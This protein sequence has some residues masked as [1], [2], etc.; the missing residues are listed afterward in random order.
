MFERFTA[1][2]RAAV[3][4]AAGNARAAGTHEIVLD[5]LLAALLP[6]VPETGLA[7]DAVADVLHDLAEARRRAGLSEAD[8]RALAEF[9]IDLDAV[10]AA[11]ERELGEGV[12]TAG[13]RRS[14]G[15][16]RLAPA[17]REA[18]AAALRQARALCDRELRVQHL[19]LGVLAQRADRVPADVLAA[20]GVTIATLIGAL[21]R[22]RRGAA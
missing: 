12:L 15:R 19:L 6:A 4:T 1:A 5:H 22:A 9:G 13:A 8:A 16:L 2:A 18:L 21:E 11:A 7:P 14:G 17:A 10:V 3:T 20:R